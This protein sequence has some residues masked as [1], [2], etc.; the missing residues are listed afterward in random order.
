MIGLLSV[1][2]DRSVDITLSQRHELSPQSVKVVKQFTTPVTVKA[3]VR[4]NPQVKKLI[5]RIVAKYQQHAEMNLLFENIDTAVDLVREYGISRDGELIFEY[6][7]R[8]SHSPDLS[9]TSM[10]RALYRL[11]RSAPRRVI[12]VTGHGEREGS[13]DL[14][15]YAALFERLAEADMKVGK[16]DLNVAKS[17]PDDVD[18]LV[19]AD[20]R[21]DFSEAENNAVEKL[22]ADTINAPHSN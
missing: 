22:M 7:G 19:I 9:E 15:G 6:Q 3:F 12:F 18:L 11:L 14:S 16:L 10:T 1:R 13:N 5:G 17:V 20:A 4:G 8:R 2:Y 21:I